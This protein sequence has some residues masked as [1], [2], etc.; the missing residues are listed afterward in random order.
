MQS[1]VVWESEVRLGEVRCGPMQSDV[2]CCGPLYTDAVISL[3]ARFCEYWP[4]Y[5]ILDCLSQRSEVN[6]WDFSG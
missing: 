2:V 3:I 5:V 1:E 4:L 6:I